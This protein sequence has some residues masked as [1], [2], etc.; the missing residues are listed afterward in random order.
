ERLE[1]VDDA[2]VERGRVGGVRAR[3]QELGPGDER[4]EHELRGGERAQ[5][6]RGRV[7]GGGGAEVVLEVLDPRPV[8]ETQAQPRRAAGGFV[9][10]PGARGLRE[11]G[12]GGEQ[13]RQRDGVRPTERSRRECSVSAISNASEL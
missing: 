7:A 13:D 3:V 11:R 6:Q 9:Q 5:R 2:R 12:R 8:L 1:R 10:A 4:A